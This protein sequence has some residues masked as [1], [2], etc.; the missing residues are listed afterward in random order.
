[1]KTVGVV[2]AGGASRRF[3]EPKAFALHNGK[4]FYKRVCEALESH[5]D[6]IVIVARNEFEDRFGNY[7]V[8]TDESDFQ[9][10]GPL[11]GLYSV[12]RSISSDWYCVLACDMPLISQ[13]AVG[14]LVD[15]VWHSECFDAV[16]PKIQGRVQPLAAMY[17]NQTVEKLRSLLVQDIRKVQVFLDE[18]QVRY[19]DELALETSPIYFQNVNRKEDLARIKGEA[20]PEGGFCTQSYLSGE[21]CRRSANIGEEEQ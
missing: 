20:A 14:S 9:G 8:I 1:M 2:L 10:M 13:A 17:H 11:A 21:A 16:V 4:Y 15:A 5:V 7:T 18:I 6:D 3:G 19:L 12:M